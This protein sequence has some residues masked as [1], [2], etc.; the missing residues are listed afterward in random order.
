MRGLAPS[1]TRRRELSENRADAV[2]VDRERVQE[3]RVRGDAALAERI[4]GQ[5][6]VI[7][8]DVGMALGCP[9]GIIMP[10]FLLA[11]CH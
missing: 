4:V 9:P 1:C 11:I 6:D 10:G 8:L 7:L 2:E 3:P 5:K